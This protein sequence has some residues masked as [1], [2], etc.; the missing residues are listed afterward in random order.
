M[1]YYDS[2][3]RNFKIWFYGKAN[4]KTEYIC[5]VGYFRNT[6]EVDSGA[7]S[8]AKNPPDSASPFR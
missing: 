3:L 2:V 4:T 6:Y 5:D 7:Y 8:I 1:K